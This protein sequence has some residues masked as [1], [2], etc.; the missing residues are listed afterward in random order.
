MPMTDSVLLAA[1]IVNPPVVSP[2][3]VQQRSQDRVEDVIEMF[4]HVFGQEPQYEV[5]AF[6]QQAGIPTRGVRCPVGEYSSM[7]SRTF[8]LR[9][10]KT[11]CGDCGVSSSFDTVAHNDVAVGP[12][13]FRIMPHPLTD[14]TDK[15]PPGRPLCGSPMSA[16][17]RISLRC[18]CVRAKLHAHTQRVL[19]ANTAGEGLREQ[20]PIQTEFVLPV[21]FFRA[22]TGRIGGQRGPVVRPGGPVGHTGRLWRPGPRP[23]GR[24]QRV[25]GTFA[26]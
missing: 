8:P 16:W 7:T 1:R 3:S 4:A 23:W 25:R 22:A 18:L 9:E 12:I 5:A 2:L 19:P 13:V 21:R 20:P 6:L 10:E 17:A 24:C 26:T 14:R 15:S 11:E